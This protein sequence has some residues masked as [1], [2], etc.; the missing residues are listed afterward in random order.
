MLAAWLH[1]A[2]RLASQACM[3]T[4][5]QRKTLSLEMFYEELAAAEVMVTNSTPCASTAASMASSRM[6]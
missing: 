5:L 1:I 2:V 3:H 6:C 4:S